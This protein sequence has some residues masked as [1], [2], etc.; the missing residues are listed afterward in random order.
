MW[1]RGFRR[2]RNFCLRR[3]R[4]GKFGGGSGTQKF[5]IGFLSEL[6]TYQEENERLKAVDFHREQS[7]KV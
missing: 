4:V 5:C 7:R 2:G 6:E 1:L 3:M